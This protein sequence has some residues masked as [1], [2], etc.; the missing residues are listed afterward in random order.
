MTTVLLHLNPRA[1]SLRLIKYVFLVPSVEAQV[2][3]QIQKL[4]LRI[5]TRSFSFSQII[6]IY[7]LNPTSTP[8]GLSQLN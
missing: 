2:E 1:V 5:L 4:S 3:A 8:T 7:F 6:S